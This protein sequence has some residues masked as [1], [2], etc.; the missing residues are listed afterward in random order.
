MRQDR[1]PREADPTPVK[2]FGVS[3]PHRAVDHRALTPNPFRL[4][5]QYCVKSDTATVGPPGRSQCRMPSGPLK[6]GLTR[7]VEVGRD[8]KAPT[9]LKA[10]PAS[11]AYRDASVSK[12]TRDILTH[13]GSCLGCP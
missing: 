13:R 11:W 12:S 2:R 8:S 4:L 3:S 5:G 7:R 10:H 9:S 6:P 1:A